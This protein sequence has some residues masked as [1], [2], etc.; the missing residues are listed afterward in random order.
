VQRR[1]IFPNI[2][3][4]EQKRGGLDVSIVQSANGLPELGLGLRKLRH[5]LTADLRSDDLEGSSGVP[6]VAPQLSLRSTFFFC[7]IKGLLRTNLE[8]PME[9]EKISPNASQNIQPVR[10]IETDDPLALPRP[11]VALCLSGGGYRA[12]LFHLGA[13]WRLN[14]VGLLK[15]LGTQ[16]EADDERA[17]HSDGH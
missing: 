10:F 11:G 3:S 15:S 1:L 2:S 9:I 12:M 13:L 5:F 4:S 14:E 17:E 6:A 7:V 8:N 16:M